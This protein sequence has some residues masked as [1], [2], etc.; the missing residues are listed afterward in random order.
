MHSKLDFPGALPIL[1][2][3]IARSGSRIDAV[4]IVHLSKDGSLIP[5]GR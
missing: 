5:P 3:M 4:E 1:Y 2:V